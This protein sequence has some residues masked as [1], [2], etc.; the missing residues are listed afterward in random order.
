MIIGYIEEGFYKI[1]RLQKNNIQTS[2]FDN[3]IEISLG[4]LYPIQDFDCS[5]IQ[6]KEIICGFLTL[7][8]ETGYA[9]LDEDKAIIYFNFP[10]N[11]F[12]MHDIRVYRNFII[13]FGKSLSSHI[14]SI[15]VYQRDEGKEIKNATKPGDYNYLNNLYGSVRNYEKSPQTLT[16]EG[17]LL[18][19][20]EKEFY[21]STMNG[22]SL[23]TYK[24]GNMT[25]TIHS[26]NNMDYKTIRD[27]TI[28]FSDTKG[29][30]Q[31]VSIRELF[32]PELYVT[33]VWIQIFLLTCC[34]N[35]IFCLIWCF[36]GRGRTFKKTVLEWTQ[37]KEQ[38]F[39]LTEPAKVDRTMNDIS[40]DENF[41]LEL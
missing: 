26:L 36:F 18:F 41:G 2:K 21:L 39:E 4:K 40:M 22:T 32:M 29:Q 1:R 33:L 17:I 15:L 6:A 8:H 37:T 7:D 19:E 12:E 25:M 35:I 31:K 14:E 13:V 3:Q 28:I 11:D 24:F 30:Q 9:I 20:Q 34:V 23:D 5:W 16:R 38:N 27:Y 10:F